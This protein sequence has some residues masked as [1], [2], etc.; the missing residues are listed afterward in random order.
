MNTNFN[1]FIPTRVKVACGQ[2][3]QLHNKNLPDKKCS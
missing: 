2:L 1:F 3:N